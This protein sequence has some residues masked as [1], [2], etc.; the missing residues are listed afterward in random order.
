M[1]AIYRRC[2]L[3]ACTRSLYTVTNVLSRFSQDL[4]DNTPAM[5]D[6]QLR[7]WLRDSSLRQQCAIRLPATE[8]FSGVNIEVSISA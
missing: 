3:Y 6:S 2:L 1:S 5:F 8:T 7:C 4:I